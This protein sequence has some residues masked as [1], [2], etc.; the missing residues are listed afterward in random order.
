MKSSLRKGDLNYMRK[1]PVTFKVEPI[2]T[3][4]QGLSGYTLWL[5]QQWRK[6]TDR[7]NKLRWDN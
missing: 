3:D 2:Y 5:T 1:E 7:E 4:E 6:E